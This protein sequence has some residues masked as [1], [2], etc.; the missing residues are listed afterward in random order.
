MPAWLTTASSRKSDHVDESQ[1]VVPRDDHE[2]AA[3][4]NDGAAT[5]G[6]GQPDGTDFSGIA[7]GQDTVRGMA[8]GKV[9]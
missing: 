8:S 6:I 4:V 7:R 3:R 9:R 1:P 5:A 2:P